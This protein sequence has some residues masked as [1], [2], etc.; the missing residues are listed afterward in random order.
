M[1]GYLSEGRGNLKV[2]KNY[3]NIIGVALFQ[4][5]LSNVSHILVD[6][7]YFMP[8]YLHIRLAYLDCIFVRHFQQTMQSL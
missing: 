2:A 7:I 8:H 1:P 4:I 5:P 3:N 6:Y